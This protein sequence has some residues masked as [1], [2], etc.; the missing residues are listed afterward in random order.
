MHAHSSLADADWY[1]FSGPAGNYMPFSPPSDN[2]CGTDKPGW[3]ATV[4]PAIGG[5]PE[6]SRVCFRNGGGYCYWSTQIEVC[7]CSVDFG[8]TPVYMYKLPRP[9]GCNAA[10][11]G[12][13]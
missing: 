12:H 9:P 8:A 3:L 10:Y 6:L 4:A 1:R 11:C 13:G 2:R 7:T 5:P